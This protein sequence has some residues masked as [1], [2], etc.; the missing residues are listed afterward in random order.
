MKKNLKRIFKIGFITAGI[1]F[2]FV[3]FVSLFTQTQFFRDRLRIIL[4]SSI[5]SKI[6]GTLHIGTIDGNLLTGFTI[7]SVA[8]SQNGEMLFSTGK[9]FCQYEPFGFFSKRATFRYIIVEQPTIRLTRSASGQWNIASILKPD[10]AN[11]N[12]HFD[13]TLIF[14]DVEIK[15]GTI[16]VVDSCSLLAP[17]HWNLPPS[18]FEYHNFS[19]NDFNLT[20]HATVTEKSIA[21]NIVHASGYSPQS[22]FELTHFKGNFSVS[23]KGTFANNIILQTGHSYIELDG[24]IANVNVMNDFSL[25]RLRQDSVHLQVRAKN[26]DVGELK[27]FLPQVDFLNGSVFLDLDVGGEFGNIFIRHLHLNTFRSTVNLSGSVRNLHQPKNLSLGIIVGDTKIDPTDISRILPSLQVPTFDSVGFVTVY[28]EFNG[29]P[30]NFKSKT[31]LKGS[32]GS[33]D[34]NG[35]MNLEQDQPSYA[36]SLT[37]SRLNLGPIIRNKK[38]NTMLNAKGT[39]T[40]HGFSLDKLSTTVWFAADSSRIQHLNLTSLTCTLRGEPNHIEANIRAQNSDM[41][42]EILAQGDYSDTTAPRY[43]AT[44]DLSSFDLA[45]ILN[46]EKFSSDLTFQGS[47]SGSGHRIDDLNAESDLT[48]LPSMFQG[49]KVSAQDIH[50]TLDQRQ[51]LHKHLSLQS[52]IAD[53]DL[54]GEF[55]LDHMTDALVHQTNNLIDSI[56]RHASPSDSLVQESNE[57]TL[58]GNHPWIDQKK[59]NSTYT[60]NIKDLEPLAELFKSSPF[61]AKAQLS[62]SLTGTAGNLSLRCTGTFDEC[63]F[64]TVKGGIL[65][66]NGTIDAVLDSLKDIRTLEDLTANARFTATSG[67]LNTKTIE[68]LDASVSY[69]NLAGK[70]SLHGTVDSLYTVNMEGNASVQPHTYV[71]DFDTLDLAAGPYQWINDQDVQ[72]R[73]NYDGFRIMHGVMKR[74]NEQFTLVGI[75]PSTGDMDFTATL[76][77]FDLSGIQNIVRPN[78]SPAGDRLFTGTADAELHLSGSMLAPG[79][80]FD[81]NSENT[82]YKQTRIGSF[83]AHIEYNKQIAL[84]NILNMDKGLDSIPRLVIKGSLPIDL[85]FTNVEERFPDTS[86][87]IEIT[88]QGFDVG[89]LEPLLPDLSNLSGTVKSNVIIAGTPRQPEFSGSILLNNIQFLFGPNNIPYSISGELQPSQDKIVVKQLRVQ[90]LDPGGKGN[91]ATLTGSISVKNFEIGEF[92]LIAQ[93]K[94]LLM[95]EATRRRVPTMFGTLLT[96]TDDEGLHITGTPEY[97]L[98]SGKLYILDANLTF[99]PATTALSTSNNLILP[100]I[101]VDDT[102][103]INFGTEKVSKFYAV[104]DSSSDSLQFTAIK[105]SPLLDRLRYN[106]N[107]ETRGLTV[108]RMI[109]SPTT[110]QELYA[111]L[112]GKVTAVN[113]NGTPSIYGEIEVGSRSY[114]SFVRKFDATGKLKFIGEWDNPELDVTATYQGVRQITEPQTI[115]QEATTTPKTT[116][117]NVLVELAITGPRLNPKL[118]MSMKVQLRP[119]G[120]WVDWSTQSQGGDVQSDVFSFILWGKFHDQLTSK[121]QQDVSNIGSSTGTSVA[122][123]LVSGI[124]S[125]L[126][127]EE[128]PF[129]RDVDFSYE[130]GTIQEG[131]NVNVT[132]SPGIGQLRVG[133]KIFNDIGNTNLSYQINLVRNLFLEI[134]RKVTSENTEDK[135]LTNEAR[136]YYRF[137]F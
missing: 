16:V 120:D 15:H 52:G 14:D 107:I 101:V 48:F 18:Y 43:S 34:I 45:S 114:Y 125:D 106:L 35:E 90:N 51:E 8:L 133:G 49:H 112:D 80:L 73:W 121:E 130:G 100:Y 56:Q 104:G 75:L 71:F 72:C 6:N 39:I 42:A 23:D 33:I 126:V 38:F 102:T 95:T 131:T 83:R 87:Y 113:N 76:K 91:E 115:E 129:I 40:G 92:N 88:S 28:S 27:S 26:L 36:G 25:A 105:A 124:F 47:F 12:N 20:L 1:V 2:L 13:W 9:I 46:D 30:L 137:A 57:G 118:A 68:H 67:K 103:K 63:Y 32:F 69:K 108:V 99:P 96:E 58:S 79:I 117:Q 3:V 53:I 22:R 10:S 60:I 31:S 11:T 61:D 85:G 127:R 89:V 41:N 70:I 59:F 29:R 4:A 94:I 21:A 119:G 116:D 44:V 84:L 134:Q 109:F 5:T 81:A 77:H 55:D 110:N 97:P 122:S 86:E 64:G 7:D 132:T 65:L 128:L 24:S 78:L 66:N 93:G 37:T 19:V 98:L 62:G 74:N 50:L 111:E 54:R 136:L 123:N 135:R 17:D 82:F